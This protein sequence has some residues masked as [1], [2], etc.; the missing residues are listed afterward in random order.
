[1]P[2]SDFRHPRFF[3][4][5]ELSWLEFNARVLQEAQDHTNPVLERLK[6][7]SIFTGN[8]EEF[9]MI[10][11]A[12]LRELELAGVIDTRADGMTPVEQLEAISRRS[13]QLVQAHSE[14][15]IRDVL[16]QLHEQGIH[17]RSAAELDPAQRDAIAERFRNEI[18]AVLTPMTVDPSHP[19]PHLS[20][21]SLNLIVTFETSTVE[22]D[23]EQTPDDDDM[24]FAIV[25][26]PRV[27][28]PLI[29][30]PPSGR[31]VDYVL[32]QEAVRAHLGEL[33]KGL[34]IHN[35]WLFRVT[36]NSDLALEEQDVENLMKDLERELRSRTF[37]RVVRLEVETD[38]PPRVR[39]VLQHGLEVGDRDVYAIDRM[40]HAPLLMGVYGL[41]RF[42]YL[43]DQPFNPR[44]SPALANPGSIFSILR[45]H[46]ILLHHPYESFSTV[47]ELLQHAAHDPKVLAIKLTLYRTSGDSV[48]IQALKDA[49]ENGKQVTAVVELKARFD[50]KNNI[51]WARQ[52]ERAGCHVVYGIVGLK[53]HCKAALVVRKEGTHVRRY[54]HLATGNYNSTT[55]RLY[56]DVGLLTQDPRIGE[57]ISQLFNILTG[58]NARNIHDVVAGRQPAP[59]FHKI[60]VSP[61]SLRDRVLRFIQDEVDNVQAGKT[62][63]IRAKINS[64]V[65]PSIITALYRASQAGVKIQLCVRGICCLRPGIDGVSDNIEVI[66]IVDRFLE[67]PRIFHFHAGGLDRVYLASADWMPRNLFRR[68]ELMF[69]IEQDDIKRRI[70]AEILDLTFAD[71]VKARRLQPDGTYHYVPR[72]EDEPR[73]RSQKRFIE[74]AREAGI[75]SLPYESALREAGR[76]G[77]GR[78]K[79]AR[80]PRGG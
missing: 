47:A 66:S 5:R 70:M 31:G 61:F 53:T 27:L 37:R 80:P 71:N 14:C 2:E 36:R 69:P 72:A 32:M 29:E 7:L 18:F 26:I 10:R 20:N 11:V 59:E 58:Y 51:V 75:K 64:L 49:A 41:E 24:P 73:V 40:L 16:P 46:D 56:T 44:L 23:G 68:I 33:F 17:F 52:L 76:S 74:L 9:F 78:L 62:A 50:E 65:D 60:F 63:F 19:F 13:H 12:N 34:R 25:E 54:V 79:P 38:M 45:E 3:T 30:V 55:A 48:I 22:S 21:Q 15:L 6:F 43:R 42:R 1:M 39:A 57:D 77:H 35:A 4:N 67:H 28:E 8:L